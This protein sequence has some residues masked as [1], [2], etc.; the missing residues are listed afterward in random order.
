MMKGIIL[1][2]ILVLLWQD[3][4]TFAKTQIRRL[5]PKDFRQLPAAIVESL[6][7]R[8]CLI[9]QTWRNRTPHN[10][11]RGSF[12]SAQHHDWAV[13]CSRKGTSSILIFREDSAKLM[14]EIGAAK[15][16]GFLQDV[17]GKGTSGYSRAISAVNQDYIL[18]HHRRSG[19]PKPPPI[20]HEG[21]EGIDDAFVEKASVVRY[22]HRGKWL[23]LQ[24]AD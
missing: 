4:S 8:G 7:A 2:A 3:Q 19:G 11:I 20:N 14:A 15:D 21:H 13:L 1:S 9:P 5:P 24:G 10:V 16:E 18:E 12:I 6:E 23:L 22:F 17:D